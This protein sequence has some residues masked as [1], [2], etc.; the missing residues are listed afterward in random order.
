MVW[1]DDD[2]RRVIEQE[3]RLLTA[4]VRRSAAEVDRLLHP[5]FVEFGA[6][7]RRWDRSAMIAAIGTELTDD[8]PPVVSAMTGARPADTVVLLTYQTERSG[9]RV[10][11][12]SLW[13]REQ[14]GTWRLYFHQGT[15]VGGQERARSSTQ[16]SPGRGSSPARTEPAS[17]PSSTPLRKA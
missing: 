2:V 4:E 9:R 6:S 1:M 11:R 16:H 13:C 5:D 7:G 17:S 8:E 10:R 12:S 15:P 14:D 3:R